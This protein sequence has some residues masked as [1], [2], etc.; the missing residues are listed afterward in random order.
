MGNTTSSTDKF[1]N[2]I[3]KG[4]EDELIELIERVDDINDVLEDES[5]KT[6]LSYIISLANVFAIN[7]SNKYYYNYMNGL[8]LILTH[9]K[10]KINTNAPIKIKN[11]KSISTE[12]FNCKINASTCIVILNKLLEYGIRNNT[13]LFNYEDTRSIL[14]FISIKTNIDNEHVPITFSLLFDHE[15]NINYINYCDDRDLYK[16]FLMKFIMKNNIKIVKLLLENGAD[17]NIPSNYRFPLFECDIKSEIFTLLLGHGA[18]P[19]VKINGIP[20]MNDLKITSD[21]LYGIQ[22][23]LKYNFNPNN[24]Y[25]TKILRYDIRYANSHSERDITMLEQIYDLLDLN[26]IDYNGISL[27]TRNV[28]NNEFDIV[29]LLLEKGVDINI[30]G[31]YNP[32]SRCKNI[33]MVNLLLEYGANFEIM[34]RDD[35]SCYDVLVNK[36]II[37]RSNDSDLPPAYIDEPP[38][39]Y[40]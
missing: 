27:L 6:L 14:E 2:C 12:L 21:N 8:D 32:L 34:V 1:K 33:N 4:D 30:E 31:L 17:P 20:K 38:P 35:M 5:N 3:K 13:I 26:Q 18:D 19:N 36:G 37:D 11:Y 28:I 16:T 22:T 40:S 15:Y 9:G 7:K 39:P 10:T 23:L 29:S 24:N 25:I